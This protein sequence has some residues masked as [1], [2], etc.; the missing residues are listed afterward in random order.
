MKL[1]PLAL[2]TAAIGRAGDPDPAALS[3]ARALASAE[4]GLPQLSIQLPGTQY[5][6]YR[7]KLSSEH[8]LAARRSLEDLGALL[9]RLREALAAFDAGRGGG[10]EAVALA[11]TFEQ[12]A[13]DA[14]REGLIIDEPA[15][16]FF[17]VDSPRHLR[18][19]LVDGDY[20]M[21]R[22]DCVPSAGGLP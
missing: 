2:L 5:E 6:C 1:L 10:D 12:K 15:H 16:A 8:G 17:G 20:Q 11:Q 22:G 9:G 4:I 3:A 18:A 14:A 7:M 21:V 13:G 19:S